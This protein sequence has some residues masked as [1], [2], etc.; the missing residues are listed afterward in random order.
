MTPQGPSLAGTSRSAPLIARRLSE[1]SSNEVAAAFLTIFADYPVAPPAG[2][3]GESFD[4]RMV[5]EH[6][7]RSASWL[8]TRGADPVAV[9]LVARRGWTS[10]I[11]GL[12]VAAGHRGQGLGRRILTEACEAARSRGDRRTLVEVPVSNTAAIALYESLGFAPR[13]RLVGFH[14]PFAGP[15]PDA[16][17]REV[18][19]LEVAAVLFTDGPADLPW[20]LQPA[21][22][23]GAMLPTRA[24]ALDEAAYAVATCRDQMMHLRCLFVK[25]GAR[26][27]GLGRRLVDAL[28][29]RE[30]VTTCT[31]QPMVPEGLCDGFFTAAGFVRVPMEHVEMVRTGGASCRE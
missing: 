26:R 5:F 10:H 19:A 12:G 15:V 2:F 22:L 27:R 28:A 4:R 21:S 6:L 17:I 24:Y 30:G 13:R 29:C 16:P 14:K 31:V 23:A 3:D 9:I 11:S 18:D 8:W 25:P 20:L 1:C 7:D